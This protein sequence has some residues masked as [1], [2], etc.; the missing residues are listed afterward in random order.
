M[1]TFVVELLPS[2]DVALALVFD[3]VFPLSEVV[4]ELVVTVGV[5]VCAVVVFDPSALDTVV[6]LVEVLV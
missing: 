1:M 3:A 2:E 5:L 4:E 6:V